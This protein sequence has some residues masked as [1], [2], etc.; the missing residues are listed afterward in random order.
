VLIVRHTSRTRTDIHVEGDH[1]QAVVMPHAWPDS[2]RPWDAT[3]AALKQHHCCARFTLPGFDIGSDPRPT[4]LDAMC[5]WLQA[6]DGV[7]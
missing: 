4:T 2:H 6:G 1:S 7:R 3:V 5:E